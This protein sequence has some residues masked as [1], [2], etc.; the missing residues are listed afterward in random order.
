MPEYFLRDWHITGNLIASIKLNVH[1]LTL[2][3]LIPE[4]NNTAALQYARQ[5]L[6]MAMQT[7]SRQYIRDAYQILYSVYDRLHKTDSAYFYYQKYI[8]MKDIVLSDQIKGKFAAYNYEQKIALLNKEKQ[9]QQQQI[10]QSAQQ[11][12]FL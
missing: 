1:Y 5:G 7:K 2:Q 6:N 9:L 3:K 8:V 10:K 4:N 11:K 12:N